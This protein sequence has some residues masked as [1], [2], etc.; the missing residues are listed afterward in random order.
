LLRFLML[1]NSFYTP[2]PH[3]TT[4]HIVQMVQA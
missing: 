4:A 2:R 1:S 3:Q